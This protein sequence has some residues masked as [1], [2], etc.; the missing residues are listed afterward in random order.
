[1][2]R[3]TAVEA[4]EPI[5]VSGSG[6]GDGVIRRIPVG[7]RDAP[8]PRDTPDAAASNGS[9]EGVEQLRKAFSNK[10]RHVVAIHSKSRPTCLS[11]DTTETPSFLGF[12]NLMYGVLICIRCHDFRQNDIRLGLALYL[13]IPSRQNQAPFFLLPLLPIRHAL[14]T[15]AQSRTFRNT[16]RLIRLAHMINITAALGFHT[17]IV[18]YHIHHPLIGTLTETH[19]I[20]V[21]L[22][23]A[24]YALTNR[25]LRHA[26]LH[27]PRGDHAALPELYQ[28]CPYPANIRFR[29]LVYFWWAPT[30]VYQPAYPR[31]ERVRESLGMYWRT[32]NKPVTQYFRRHVY[33]PMR[34]RGYSHMFAS[35]VV[36]FVSAVL[37]ELLVGAPTH[38]LIGVA[39]MGMFLQLP[40]IAMT[41]PL[42]RNKSANGKLLGNVTFW[43]TFT[44]FGQPL[45]ALL[46]FYAWQAKYGSVSRGM[47][48]GKGV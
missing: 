12:R 33:S 40:L 1:M 16:W 46:Y 48:A 20:I 27:P 18:Y 21:W 19:A 24:S 34:A 36:F 38:N 13:L 17:W 15:P 8:D 26:Y 43:V 7:A 11:H 45:A 39:F 35:A 4:S 2:T 10:Y 32:W 31:S 14:P 9:A 3:S 30:L 29:N 47:M 44:I 28:Q 37:H 6:A 25:D 23:T 5:A 42:E 22:K 41:A